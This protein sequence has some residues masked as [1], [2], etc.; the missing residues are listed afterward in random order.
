ME[1]WKDIPG[2]EGYYQASN[3]GRVRSVSR[4]RMDGLW[5]TGRVLKP[6]RLKDGYEQVALKVNKHTDY[7]KVH[8]LVALTFIANP[9]GKPQVNHK[10]GIKHDNMVENL[11]WMTCSENTLHAYRVLGVQPS[12]G[13]K[14]KPS[15]LRKLSDEQVDAIRKDPRTRTAIAKDYGVCQQTISNI[16]LGYYYNVKQQTR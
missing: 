2:Y 16:K 13:P 8:R 5:K 4:R 9:E 10:N 12:C 7:E 14:G 6:D 15:P 11:E 1:V 3:M